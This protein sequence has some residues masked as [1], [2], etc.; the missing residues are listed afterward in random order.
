MGRRPDSG[1]R[2]SGR[3]SDAEAKLE[4]GTAGDAL[5]TGAFGGC[6]RLM[7]SIW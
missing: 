2:Y 5:A 6:S 7:R 4:G 3:G 1:N